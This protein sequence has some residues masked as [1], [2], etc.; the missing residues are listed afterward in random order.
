MRP[1]VAATRGVGYY[2]KEANMKRLYG[3][4]SFIALPCSFLSMLLA[5]AI[6][7]CGEKRRRHTG[8][9]PAA[10]GRKRR[11]KPEYEDSTTCGTSSSAATCCVTKSRIKRIDPATIDKTTQAAQT[12]TDSVKAWKV[13]DV[14]PNGDIEIHERRANGFT[15]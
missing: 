12:K 13:T 4:F 3:R 11:P 5:V 9:E 1:S 14:L 10:R 2:C 8:K 7:T 15:W 6:V